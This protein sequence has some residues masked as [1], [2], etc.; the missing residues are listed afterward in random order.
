MQ[1][2]GVMTLAGSVIVLI[3]LLLEWI[4]KERLEARQKYMLLKIALC[5][6]LI[7]SLPVAMV[8]REIWLSLQNEIPVLAD[9]EFPKLEMAKYVMYHT[10][11][12]VL[13]NKNLDV[14]MLSTIV[15]LIVASVI[16]LVGA[17][18]SRIQV[19]KMIKR[20]FLTENE[21]IKV[22]L[23]KYKANYGIRRKYMCMNI[24]LDCRL[25]P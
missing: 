17:V 22:L 1:Y 7:P 13:F 24:R 16:L 4:G 18:K 14:L 9:K 25:L 23:E 6:Y 10:E 19:N 5:F 2:I 8:Y 20:S 3:F 11:E 12:G 15:W 21:N